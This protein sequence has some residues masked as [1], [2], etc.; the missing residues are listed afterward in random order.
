[1]KIDWG[2]MLTII[3]ALV[4]YK[5]VDKFLLS[6]VTEKLEESFA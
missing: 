4:V 5:L 6:K 2:T 3:L 1:M